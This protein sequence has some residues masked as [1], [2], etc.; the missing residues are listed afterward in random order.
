MS[1]QKKEHIGWI[2]L[3]RIIAIFLMVLS[4]SCDGFVSQ[5]DTNRNAF[6]TGALTG[7]FVRA[8]VPLFAMMTGVLLFPVR[9]TMT[10]FY[11]KR[12]GRIAL[13]LIFWSLV[14]PLL[15]YTYYT[16][17]NPGT[18]NAAIDVSNHTLEASLTKMYTWIFNFNT[19]TT[20]LWYLY[21]LIGLYLIIPIFGVWVQQASKKEMKLF[22]CLWFVSLLLP[23]LQMAA[24]FLGYTGNYGSM[25]ILGESFWNKFGTF[26]YV[27][28][29][30]GY[31]ILAHYLVR[32]PLSWTLK[33]TLSICIPLFALGYA[34][35][36]FGFLKTQEAFPGNYEYLEI[37]WFF[38]GINVF[39]MTI[40]IFLIV[41]KLNIKSFPLLSKIAGLMF[42]V[43]LIHFLIV[44]IGYDIFDTPV[45]SDFARILITA[46][47]S[48]VVSLIIVWG[49][50]KV[51]F[52]QK[53][54]R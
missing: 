43:F 19:D 4:H 18:T 10:E 50:N 31:L 39:M 52:M 35:T 1:L 16:Y 22:L 49:L 32:Y 44:Q 25:A 6:V 47:F 8:C 11:K 2:D 9:G 13:P 29:F 53:F 30:M 46:V 24:P 34:I 42:G 3:L 41:Q 7:S 26:Y 21:M 51:S 20:P 14:T 38:C 45:L 54:I 48:F 27:S 5:L 37:V 28:G 40:S 36:G 17:I 33:K 12:L 23:Y 15:F